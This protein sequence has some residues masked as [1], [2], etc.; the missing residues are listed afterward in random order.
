M[1][2][3]VKAVK[4]SRFQPKLKYIKQNK[5]LYFMLLPTLIFF[6]VFHVIPICGMKLAFFDYKIMGD[7]VFAGLKYFQKLSQHLHFSNI[8]KYFDY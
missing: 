2:N 4:K 6:L 1:A 7:D 3:T 5:V 8:R